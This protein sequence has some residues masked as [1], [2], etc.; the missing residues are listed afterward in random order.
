[1]NWPDLIKSEFPP[2]KDALCQVWLK[3]AKWVWRRLYKVHYF[4]LSPLG[5][6]WISSSWTWSKVIRKTQLT[7]AFSSVEHEL[8]TY[9]HIC[10]FKWRMFMVRWFSLKWTCIPFIFTTLSSHSLSFVFYSHWSRRSWLWRCS[11]SVGW[12]RSGVR[13]P[14]L[15]ANRAGDSAADS[16]WQRPVKEK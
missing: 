5:Q 11:L 12:W 8:N 2:L 15:S 7:W 3:L 9:L 6:S 16:S 4:A 10:A 1:M 14:S 13:D